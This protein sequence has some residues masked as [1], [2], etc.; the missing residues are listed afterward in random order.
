M[1]HLEQHESL[2]GRYDNKSARNFQSGYF[3]RGCAV[4]RHYIIKPHQPQSNFRGWEPKRVRTHSTP[5]S[6]RLHSSV[7]LLGDIGE[8]LCM[9]EPTYAGGAHSNWET[10]LRS[11]VRFEV[12][13]LGGTR[14][15]TKESQDTG[16][17]AKNLR[18]QRWRFS[19]SQY[20]DPSDAIKTQESRQVS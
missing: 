12:L 18:S 8:C 17:G 9:G 19:R 5:D 15:L 4:L 20:P 11:T 7:L 14:G 10:C 1:N 2:V 13:P 6:E 16:H 3:P